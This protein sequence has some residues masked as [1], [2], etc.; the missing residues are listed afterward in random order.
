MSTINIQIA[1]T[2]ES[3]EFGLQYVKEMDKMSGMLFNFHQPRILSF[4]GKNTY[5]PLD[6]AF[7]NDNGVIV[8]TEQIVPLSLK[9]VSCNVPCSFALEVPAGTLDEIGCKEGS[10]IDIDWKNKQ[11]IFDDQN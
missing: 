7:I 1:D 2:P 8:K 6:I 3:R 11:V 10:T 4:W 9:S 5:M